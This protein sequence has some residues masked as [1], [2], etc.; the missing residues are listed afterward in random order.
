MSLLPYVCILVNSVDR[1]GDFIVEVFGCGD[2]QGEVIDKPVLHRI[3]QLSQGSSIIIAQKENCNEAA[4]AT[5]SLFAV[6]HTLIAV[7]DIEKVRSVAI[8][9]GAQVIRNDHTERITICF[10]DGVEEIFIHV[11]DSEKMKGYSTDLIMTSLI[12]QSSNQE[13]VQT[14]D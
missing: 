4:L 12:S 13:V 6:K 14:G 8:K 11:M 3:I 10:Y 2:D 9:L 5:F 7:E 1:V